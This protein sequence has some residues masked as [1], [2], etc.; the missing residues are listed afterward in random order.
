MQR[1]PW[2]PKRNFTLFAV[3]AWFDSMY[4]NTLIFLPPTAATIALSPLVAGF[5]KA[6]FT[7]SVRHSP[8]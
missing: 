4:P 6:Y 7:G 2:L 3:P 5:A 1:C 8:S